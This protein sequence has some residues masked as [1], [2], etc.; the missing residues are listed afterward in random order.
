M[1]ESRQHSRPFGESI[2]APKDDVGYTGHKF[3]TDLGLSYMQARYYDPMIGRFYSNDP[4]GW[5][6]KNPVMSFNRYLYVNNNPYKYTD[7]NGEFLNFAIKFV[8]DVALG[9]ALNYAETGS[10]NLG[11]A[12]G[13]AAAGVLNPAK[14]LQKVKRLAKVLKKSPCSLSCFVADTEV[15]TKDGHKSIENIVVGDLVWAKNVETGES[16]WKPVTHTWI[17]E[18]KNIYEIGVTSLN[19]TYQTIEAT[20]SHPFFVNDKGWVDTTDL[21]LGDKFVDNDGR[22]F[23]VSSLRNL[24]RKDTAYNFTVA[25]FDTY[26]V[27]QENIL[28][29]NCG[30]VKLT[31]KR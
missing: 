23:N 27:T 19:G 24:D 7:P 16:E 1:N 18:D 17:V 6:P 12:V 2:E 20:K 9:A 10:V 26:Y 21:K 29:H 30:G 15:L 3:D 13:D 28:V 8:A 4:V 11:A 14:T 22:P 5:T 31:G 25:D